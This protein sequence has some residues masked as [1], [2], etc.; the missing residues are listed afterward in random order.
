MEEFVR[1]VFDLRTLQKQ[2][3][4]NHDRDTLQKCKDAEKKVDQFITAYSNKE[5]TVQKSL[6]EE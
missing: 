5:I 3:F 2:F 4:K 1:L 6:F